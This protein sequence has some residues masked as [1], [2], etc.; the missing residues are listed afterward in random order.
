MKKLM[1][2]YLLMLLFSCSKKN[3]EVKIE[4]TK[5]DFYLE[6]VVVVNLHEVCLTYFKVKT[7]NRSN[8]QIVLQDNSLKDLLIN[9]SKIKKEGFYI[10]SLTDNSKIIP[11]AIDKYYFYEIGSKANGYC[12]ITALDLKY[13]Y[14]AK[15]SLLLKKS[16]ANYQLEYNGKNFDLSK[17]KK[18]KYINNNHYERFIKNRNKY[19]AYKDSMSIRI[20]KNIEIKYMNEM[21]R[22]DEW[23]KL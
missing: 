17:I 6:K 13:S 18:S 3:K 22:I 12:F 9:P 16:L 14:K 10:K 4:Q 2:I 15:D 5:I 1:L 21:P 19:V 11:L 8:Q 23:D 20:P 7:T